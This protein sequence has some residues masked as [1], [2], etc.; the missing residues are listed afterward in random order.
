MSNY[1]KPNGNIHLLPRFIRFRDA[2]N[3][4]GM[5]KN[6]FSKEVRP[7]LTEIP[8]GKQGKAYD[9]LELDDWAVHYKKC[10]GRSISNRDWR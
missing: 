1:Q 2:P 7:S 5:D 8:N 6:R 3:Y 9:R 4:L 10:N